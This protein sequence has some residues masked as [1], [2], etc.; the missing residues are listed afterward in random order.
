MLKWIY[1]SFASNKEYDTP[2]ELVMSIRRWRI[3]S[4]VSLSVP[5]L[6][7]LPF[8]LAWIAPY[9]EDSELTNSAVLEAINTKRYQEETGEIYQLLSLYTKEK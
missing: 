5:A 6:M 9:F 2:G 8:Y 1:A 4:A 7:L 3:L